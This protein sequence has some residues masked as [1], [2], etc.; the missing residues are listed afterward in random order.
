MQESFRPHKYAPHTK[1]I[2]VPLVSRQKSVVNVSLM[3]SQ[4]C[5]MAQYGFFSPRKLP[6][7]VGSSQGR[8]RNF[9]HRYS[10]SH[11]CG[12]N[13]CDTV[14]GKSQLLATYASW[15]INTQTYMKDDT[16]SVNGRDIFHKR[17]VGLLHLHTYGHHTPLRLLLGCFVHL[18]IKVMS[19]GK[20]GYG[21]STHI[22]HTGS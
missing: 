2:Y 3:V 21:L 19:F 20:A 7:K 10:F 15:H 4:G 12:V 9:K 1:F 8:K 5:S 6:G 11:F 14:S 17:D 22:C 16:R 18:G 13:F